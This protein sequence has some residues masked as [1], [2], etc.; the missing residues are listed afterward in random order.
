MFATNASETAVAFDESLQVEGATQIAWLHRVL[1]KVDEV[2]V[3][4]EVAYTEVLATLL[5]DGSDVMSQW[6]GPRT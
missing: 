4:V 1:G 2:T 3:A 5:R 6:A